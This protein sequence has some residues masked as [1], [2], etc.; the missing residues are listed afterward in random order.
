MARKP[1]PKLVLKAAQG[2]GYTLAELLQLTSV[3][4]AEF[5]Q[6]L[7]QARGEMRSI[8]EAQIDGNSTQPTRPRRN[9]P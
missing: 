9:N 1:V 4:I 6:A 8:I 3:S 5:R 2:K 7:Q